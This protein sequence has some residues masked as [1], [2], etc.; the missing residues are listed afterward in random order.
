MNA[1]AN[2]QASAKP[3]PI[4]TD[5]NRRFWDAC[6][7]GRLVM[8]QCDACRHIRW[9]IQALCPVCLGDGFDWAELSGRGEVFASVIY[10]RAFN[11]AFAADVPYDLVLVQLAEG[12]RMYSN[13]VEGPLEDIRVGAPITVLFDEV[14]AG[15]SVPRFRLVTD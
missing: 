12:P 5:E 14:A 13:V 6:A 2:D 7:E 1:A 3:L 11:P 4:I 15:V 9:P 10:R 8:Q